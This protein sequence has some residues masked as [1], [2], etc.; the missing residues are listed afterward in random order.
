M[1][2]M[3]NST[4]YQAR[5]RY[6]RLRAGSPGPDRLGAFET[7][8]ERAQA[9]VSW[10]DPRA[11]KLFTGVCLAIIV[12]LYAVPPKMVAVALGFYYFRHPMF[13]EPMQPASLNFFRRLSSLS[14][15]LM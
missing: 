1:S 10:R 5:A 11:T 12:V 13:R 6:D 14:D 7:Q 8:G 9:L 3:R 4:L 2:L 15:R